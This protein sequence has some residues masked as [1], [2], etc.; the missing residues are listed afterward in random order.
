MP[1]RSG[2][3]ADRAKTERSL[4]DFCTAM[5]G[6]CPAATAT[7]LVWWRTPAGCTA[8][9]TTPIAASIPLSFEAV[10]E[11][12]GDA[13]V[14]FTSGLDW[15]KRADVLAANERYGAF[16]AFRESRVYNH[17]AR[18]NEHKANDYWESGIIEPDIVLA[19]VIKILHPDRLPD[20]HLKYYRWLP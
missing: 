11:R 1:R 7:S 2:K 10:F 20:H 5:S 19:D 4:A 3:P 9:P 17:N 12:A 13:K 16:A 15:F 6:M 14:W 18:V 8:G